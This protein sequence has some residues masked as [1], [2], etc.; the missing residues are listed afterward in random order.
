MLTQQSDSLGPEVS[1]IPD[2]RFG[3]GVLALAL[4][5]IAWTGF[6]AYIALDPRPPRIPAI[7]FTTTSLGGHF[8]V[9]ALATIWLYLLFRGIGR[10][11]MRVSLLLAVAS[12]LGLGVA[13]EVAQ[14]AFSDVRAFQRQDI[15][16]DVVGAA[17]ASVFIVLA[18]VGAMALA[19]LAVAT[20]IASVLTVA[21]TLSV[22]A[23][24]DPSLPYQGDHWHA[25][26]FIVICGEV[27]EPLAPFPGA[28]HSHG[29]NLIHIHPAS[30]E[31]SGS[32]ANLGM[33][34]QNAGGELTDTSLRMPDGRQF[35]HGDSCSGQAEGEVSVRRIDTRTGET[36][37]IF[38][39]ASSVV[40]ED[41]ETLVIE[42]G[43]EPYQFSFNR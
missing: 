19:R 34:M 16:A 2:R 40:P 11:S 14:S 25:Q 7:S 13:V 42:F 10:L 23:V 18:A 5:A 3:A 22:M 20:A 35:V 21:G 29:G 30:P 8:I 36:L 33:F 41:G 43:S 17:V 28:I 26:Y 9:F 32:N 39:S 24:W 12:S 27:Q 31:T 1:P 38:D 6:F 37:H 15:A 4:V